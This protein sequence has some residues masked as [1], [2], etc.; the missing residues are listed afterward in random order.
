M[1]GEGLK[2]MQGEKRVEYLAR[3]RQ[4]QQDAPNRHAMMVPSKRRTSRKADNRN[5]DHIDGYD[6]DN[7]GESHD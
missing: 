2:Q 3:V 4:A 1:G 6:R 7:I 5:A